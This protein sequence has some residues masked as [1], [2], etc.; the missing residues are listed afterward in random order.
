MSHLCTI[1]A[2][3]LVILFSAVNLF[4]PYALLVIGIGFLLAFSCGLLRFGTPTRMRTVGKMRRF[5][6]AKRRAD[7]ANL[8]FCRDR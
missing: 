6:P 8:Y 3:A 2:A 1:L 7:P 4:L 5:P